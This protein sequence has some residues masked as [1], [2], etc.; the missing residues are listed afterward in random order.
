MNLL[1]IIS[2]NADS[3]LNQLNEDINSF[4]IV[5][6]DEKDLSRKSL[7]INLLKAKKYNKIIFGTLDIEFQRFNFF[8]SI[9]LILS[10]Y[11]KGILADNYGNSRKYS[12]IAFIFKDL[13]LFTLELF[14]SSLV[15]LYHYIKYPIIKSLWKSK[16]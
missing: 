14:L 8:I 13:S 10:G 3:I 4:D 12:P 1:L 6:I 15:I 16:S 7:I 5:K 11:S 2:G 9:Y